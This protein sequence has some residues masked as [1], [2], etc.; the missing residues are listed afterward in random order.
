[1]KQKGTHMEFYKYPLSKLFDIP[2]IVTIHYFEYGKDFVF[3]GESHDFWEFLCVD[4][5]EAIVTAHQQVHVLQKGDIIFHKPGQFHSV[6]DRKSV[7]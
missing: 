6:A 7:V 5:G 2:Q 1:M 4:K 3:E